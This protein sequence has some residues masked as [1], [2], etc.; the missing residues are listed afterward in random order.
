MS[1][2]LVIYHSYWKWPFIVVFPIK[3]GDFPLVWCSEI[4]YFCREFSISFHIYVSLLEGKCVKSFVKN[5]A[6]KKLNNSHGS[7]TFFDFLKW[8][9]HIICSFLERIILKRLG[10]LGCGVFGSTFFEKWIY[11]FWKAEVSEVE[12]FLRLAPSELFATEAQTCPRGRA[13]FFGPSTTWEN[14]AD[15]PCCRWH[16][17]RKWWTGGHLL[18]PFSGKSG[19]RTSKCHK[20]QVR[21]WNSVCH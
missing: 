17:V 3:D 8:T 21:M 4:M 1:Y 16:L 6:K 2:P 12:R 18:W 13:A 5:Q 19:N 20:P 14:H 11:I 7:A 9:D 10:R 15:V